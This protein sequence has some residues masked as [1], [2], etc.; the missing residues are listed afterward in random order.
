MS[1]KGTFRIRNLFSFLKFCRDSFLNFKAYFLKKV[2]PKG[3]FIRK[4]NCKIYVD[5]NDNNSIWYYNHNKFLIQEHEAFKTLT[6]Q[7]Q[8]N[9]VLDIGAHWGIFPAMLDHDRDIGTKIKKVICIEPDPKNQFVLKKTTSIIKN[10]GIEI[11]NCAIGSYDGEIISNKSNGTCLQ[12]Y[13]T[14]IEDKSSKLVKV[15]TIQTLLDDL[16][17]RPELVTHIKVDIDG[18]E[19]TFFFG[20]KD[21]LLK[22]KPYIITEYWFGGLSRNKDYDPYH[23]WNFLNENYEIYICN[24]PYG[25]YIKITHK[26]FEKINALTKNKVCNLL[27]HPKN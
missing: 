7:K 27:L 1:F 20:N 18:Y 5:F 2:F 14:D 3:K 23:Y 17:I 11:C 25:N 4:N 24:F 13:D 10:F 15:K 6:K 19:S 16:E 12:T 22:Y 21:F 26:D 9:V 8:P